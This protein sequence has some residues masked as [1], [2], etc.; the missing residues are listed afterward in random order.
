M[1]DFQCIGAGEALAMIEA[2]P[3]VAVFDVRDSA[4]YQRG[5]LPGAAHLT[6]DRMPGWFRKLARDQA[7]LIYCYHGN[8]SKEFAQMF[9]DF[10]F[11]QVFSVNGGYE[12][13]AKLV[14]PA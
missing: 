12:E 7:V 3:A 13:L 8:A 9:V 1:S 10:R 4:A 11:T 5:H 6:Q 14:A 2:Q